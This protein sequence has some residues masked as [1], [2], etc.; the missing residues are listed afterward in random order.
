MP[1]VN[2]VWLVR[3]RE[4]IE[5]LLKRGAP[6]A[7]LRLYAGYAGWA[8]GQLEWELSIRSWHLLRA[9][10]DRIF[11]DD[12]DALWKELEQLASAPVA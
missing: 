11:S 12:T 2:D 6:D 10:A 4:S 9:D 5:E 7:K 8:A 3:S 1:V